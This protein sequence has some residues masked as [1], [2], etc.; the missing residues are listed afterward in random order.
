VKMVISSPYFISG[1]PQSH[2]PILNNMHNIVL[3]NLNKPNSNFLP[4]GGP[5][6]CPLY[7]HCSAT[8]RHLGLCFFFFFWGVTGVRLF[9]HH[10]SIQQCNMM[11]VFYLV[12]SI[13]WH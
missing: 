10:V 3:N 11:I 13:C 12:F 7:E 8:N 2:C 6:D 5:V 1:Q 4:S 9:V